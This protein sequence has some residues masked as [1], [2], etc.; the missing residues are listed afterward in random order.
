MRPLSPAGVAADA[1]DA[2]RLRVTR[3]AARASA[4]RAAENA[5]LIL[6]SE[7]GPE[8]SQVAW[9]ECRHDA[10][11]VQT[12]GAAGLSNCSIWSAGRDEI[13]ANNAWAKL[14][15]T[16]PKDEDWD[17]WIEW[18]AERLRGGSRGEAYELVFAT[19]PQGEWNRGP[20]TANAWIKAH[21]PDRPA[22]A[23]LS[24]LPEPLPNLESPFTYGWN[25]NRRVEIVAGAQ[26]IPFFRFGGGDEDHRQTLEACR[27]GAERLLKELRDGNYSNA[28]RREY[29]QKLQYYLED[30]PTAPGAGNILL[31]NDQIVVLRGML[32]Q[33]D[34]VPSPFAV[35]LSRLIE[36]QAALNDFYELVRRHEEAVA[37]G[38][39]TQP[40][41]INAAKRFF[42]IVDENTP[43]FFEP[44][45]SK[46]IRR[47]EQ[48]AHWVEPGPDERRASSPTSEPL[49]QP[50][51]PPAPERSHL[52]Q[53]QIARRAASVSRCLWSVFLKGKDLPV[54]LEGWTQAAH[55][56]GENIG[57]LLDFLRG[58]GGT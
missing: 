23:T 11:L 2:A 25:A 22:T 19:V 3:S 7:A 41:P 13:W 6:A 36:K 53:H 34:A 24:D 39:W 50:S 45:V 8:A 14:R 52:N 12:L 44:E 27:K 30:L 10:R 46:G 20:A 9:E 33:D 1:A 32:A 51:S 57:P 4:A 5:S 55:K 49:P 47:V 21:L 17:V 37:K 38:R 48:T 26:N 58:L 54:A 43:R 35:D 15:A 42:G 18:Y 56:L 31:A 28:V 40:F 16:L 29:S